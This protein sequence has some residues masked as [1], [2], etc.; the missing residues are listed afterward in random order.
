MTRSF[1]RMAAFAVACT[2]VGVLPGNVAAAESDD[3]LKNAP[4][5][6]R[7]LQYRAARHEVTGI[8]GLT[9]GDPFVRNFL[10][11]ARYDYHLFDWLGFGGRLQVGVPVQT[12]TFAE[13]DT[14]VARSN[15]TFEMEAT[16]LQLLATAHVSVSPV[17][18]KL[19][20]FDSLP[21]NFDVHFDLSAGIASVASSG[22]NIET[23]IGFAGGAGGGLRIFLSRV[24]ALTFDLEGL[25]VDR[26]LSVNRDSKMTGRKARFNTLA[27]FGLSFFMPPKL[28]R[29]E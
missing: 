15:E 28:R 21:I 20:V 19:L 23:G 26:A 10:P 13:V 18:G 14:K 9:L 25:L 1:R 2:L 3:V 8:F 16:N 6:R 24:L 29:A 11:G 5:V 17:V 7:Q 22:D 4:V 27:S 12:A